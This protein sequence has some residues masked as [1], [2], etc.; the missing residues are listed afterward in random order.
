MSALYPSDEWI[1][2]L[3]AVCRADDGFRSSCG[4]F[5]GKFVFQIETEPG[6]LE[7]P[8]YL[9]LWV[10]QGDAKEAKAMTSL[11]EEP[12]AEYVITGKYSVWKGV[13]QGKLDP[14]RAIMTRKLKLVKGSQFTILKQAKFAMRMISNATRV[15][16]VFADER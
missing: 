11:D 6:K 3:Q 4:D 10:D 2:G 1:K 14:L 8:A 7:R 13:V 15:D 16:T 5:M 9:F 12:D